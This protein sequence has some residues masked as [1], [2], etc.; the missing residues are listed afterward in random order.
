MS[1][2]T[3]N[4][5]QFPVLTSL[6]IMSSGDDHDWN[7]SEYMVKDP[8]S[9]D[10]SD[11]DNTDFTDQD[12]LIKVNV[13][14]R[15]HFVQI[16][17]VILGTCTLLPWNFFINA[18]NYWMYKFRKVGT[19]IDYSNKTE[20][21]ATFE[22]Y[23]SVT[24][25]VS[26]T[27]F[28][29]ISIFLSN[30]VRHEIR[31]YFSMISI[32]VLM[33]C[34]TVFVKIDT[35]TWQNEFMVITLVIVVLVNDKIRLEKGVRQGDS[36]SPKIFTACLENV[37]RCLN[38][39][40][41]GIPINGHRLTNLRFADDVVLFSESPQELQLMVEELRTAS[42]KVGLEINLSKT[43]VMFNRNVEIQPIMTGNVALD[44]VDRYTYLGQLI[45]IH[46]DWEPELEVLAYFTHKVTL[47]F[48]YFVEVNSQQEL[49]KTFPQ[50]Y[51][52]LLAGKRETLKDYVIH[53]PHIPVV[54]PT[55]ALSKKILQ[56]MCTDAAEVFDRQADREY[57]FRKYRLGK[58]PR[59]TELNLLTTEQLRGLPTNNL[60]AERHLAG[61]GKRAAVANDVV[62]VL[63]DMENK[64]Y[65]EQ[66]QLLNIRIAEK[67]ENGKKKSQYTQK[68]LQLCKG[69]GGPAI[70]V[71]ELHQILRSH[72]DMKEKIARNELICYRDTDKSDVLDNPTMFKVNKNLHE[73]RLVN[74]CTLL[75]GQESSYSSALLPTNRDAEVALESNVAEVGT[76][77][78]MEIEI[79]KYYVTL[80]TEGE[81]N[82]WNIASCDNRNDDGTFQMDH[83]VRVKNGNNLT[84]KHPRIPDTLDLHYA[85]ILDCD[86]DGEWDVANNRFMTFSLRNHNAINSM[87]E[88]ASLQI[89]KWLN[90]TATAIFQGAISGVASMLP[91][92]CI[93][94]LMNGQSLG[95]V[96]ASVAN[97]LTLLGHTS[98]TTSALAYF[99]IATSAC[100]VALISYIFLHKSSYFTH[101]VKRGDTSGKLL[102]FM[103]THE[104]VQ[105]YAPL[106]PVSIL[107]YYKKGLLFVPIVIFLLFN[108]SDLS[109]RLISLWIQQPKCGSPVLHLLSF[110]RIIFPILILFCN[111]EP[112]HDLPILF[113][114]DYWLV[115][116]MVL[117]GLTNGYFFTLSMM[118]APMSVTKNEQELVGNMMAASSGSGV[119]TGTLIGMALVNTV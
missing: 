3:K 23:L 34:T 40:S 66:K 119:M 91:P 25:T 70:S 8:K 101:Y 30:R 19:K 42:Y 47:P 57:G 16:S 52:D 100:L 69:W 15:Y 110:L 64:W 14:D 102:F 26:L 103:S 80:I 85:S 35:D 4:V 83:L 75:A 31:A 114:Q 18:N 50:L 21:Q 27:T 108:V 65:N 32:T 97:I 74:L 36:I 84:W 44:Q 88:K 2:V 13:H 72:P 11:E 89:D 20:L 33:I 45:S 86:V 105:Q 48:L 87:V 117:V 53:Y 96:F 106:P 68:C 61:F 76:E 46:R 41:K 1:D 104:N 99:V 56:K 37:F 79:G 28:L 7:E 43:K 63:N 90:K 71:E 29:I 109:G 93:N 6:Q 112:R 12:S 77:D 55:S 107:S 5:D 116:L 51:T 60:E 67:I 24:A 115:A 54:N 81:C 58:Q 95:G 111:R 22:S 10:V 98:I 39:I 62:K 82:T 118:Y 38:W 92:K 78:D 17:M 94:A 113:Y 9:S 73:E 49:L 59:A